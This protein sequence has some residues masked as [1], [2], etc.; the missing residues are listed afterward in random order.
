MKTYIKSYDAKV[1]KVIQLGDLL[2]VPTNKDGKKLGDGETSNDKTPT[3]EDYTDEPM[4]T[5]KINSLAK[6]CVIQCYR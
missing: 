3:L 2:L 4:E 6:K 1:W 5:I